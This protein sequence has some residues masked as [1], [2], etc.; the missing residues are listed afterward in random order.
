MAVSIHPAV[1]GGVKPGKT[2]FAGGTLTC[3]CTLEPGDR[4]AEGQYRV[5][6]RLRLHQVLEAAGSA[7]LAGRRHRPRQAHGHRERARS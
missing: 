5:Q 7:V 4:D 6:P 2:D 1:D 3:K